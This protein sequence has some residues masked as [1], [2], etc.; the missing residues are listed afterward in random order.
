MKEFKEL[1]ELFE[2][3]TIKPTFDYVHVILALFI[4]DE[5]P[6]GIG[7]YRLKKELKIGEGTA[8]SL[9]IKLNE[10][11]RFISLLDDNIRKGHVL[12]K[13]G[14]D[15]LNN[16]K[17]EIP[18][19]TIGD[20]DML[21]EIIIEVEDSSVCICQVKNRADKISNGVAQRDAAIKIGGKGASC[22]A[23]DGER[24]SFKLGPSSSDDQELM[25]IRSEIQEYFNNIIIK[26]NSM[27]DKN[28]VIIIGLA[29]DPETA[30]LASLNAALTLI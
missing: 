22:I 25:K 10:K 9:I 24:L 27:L 29:K 2:S 1:E 28:D 26:E 3:E 17:E 19:L 14:K 20:T 21:E 5:N 6:N 11:I 18:F 4:F 7:R 13:R 23:F 16:I 12:T 30:R 15:F 8:K